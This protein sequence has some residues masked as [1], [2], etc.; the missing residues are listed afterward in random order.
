MREAACSIVCVATGHASVEWER[1]TP[2]VA[3][4]R[5]GQS[6][7]ARDGDGAAEIDA[8][9]C[10]APQNFLTNPLPPGVVGKAYNPQ[11]DFLKHE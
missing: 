9:Y 4:L 2:K 5:R 3:R 7:E 11:P 8:R 6:I 10:V 1:A